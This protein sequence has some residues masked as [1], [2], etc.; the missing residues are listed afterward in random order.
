MFRSQ[1]AGQ[2][3]GAIEDL[4]PA[5]GSLCFGLFGM[6]SAGTSDNK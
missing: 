6:C 4:S 2:P 1:I 3:N 5:A